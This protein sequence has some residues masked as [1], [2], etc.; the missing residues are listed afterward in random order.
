MPFNCYFFKSILL[1]DSVKFNTII[2]SKND[3]PLI[4]SE[5]FNRMK[6]QFPPKFINQKLSL[7]N[8]NLWQKKNPKC[9][10]FQVI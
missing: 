3:M 8:V 6:F 4:L 10:I 7:I 9:T 5:C 1:K 2:S